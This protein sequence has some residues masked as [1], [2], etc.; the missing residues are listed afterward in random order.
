MSE[1]L[2]QRAELVA[3][4]VVTNVVEH[5]HSSSRLTVSSTGSALRVSVRDY[6]PTPIPRPRPIDIDAPAGR[7][8]HLVTALAY[9]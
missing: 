2:E 6:R 1:A 3:S 5:A 8:L 7:G 4:E 9:C